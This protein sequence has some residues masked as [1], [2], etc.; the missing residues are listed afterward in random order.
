MKLI[1]FLLTAI[2]LLLPVCGSASPRTSDHHT[3]Q[4]VTL[5]IDRSQPFEL[6]VIIVFDSEPKQFEALARRLLENG[7][8]PSLDVIQ[9]DTGHI[10]YILMAQKTMMFN[11]DTFNAL[12]STLTK[13][14]NESGGN[15]S[16]KF[17]QIKK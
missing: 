2:V 1:K 5:E 9:S 12:S 3:D 10:Q 15:L 6:G 8:D 14:A 17:A 16:W 4:A 13:A 7:F 11:A